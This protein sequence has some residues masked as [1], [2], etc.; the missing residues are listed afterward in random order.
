MKGQAG[1]SIM[2][3]VVG[4]ALLGVAVVVLM[5]GQDFVKQTGQLRD[6]KVIIW[7][8]KRELRAQLVERVK[9]VSTEAAKTAARI[10]KRTPAEKAK[11]KPDACRHWAGHFYAE[12]KEGAE[13]YSVV[14]SPLTER[15][16]LPGFLQNSSFGDAYQ[17]CRSRRSLDARSSQTSTPLCTTLKAAPTTD[18]GM[19]LEKRVAFVEARVAFSDVFGTRHTCEKWYELGAARRIRL[20]YT[21]YSVEL[22]GAG[23]Y[24]TYSGL[25]EGGL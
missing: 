2:E 11:K 13:D 25:Y 14:P 19:F 18:V 15:N 1:F 20:D 8:L 16:D 9:T 10:D 22:T 7:S 12:V 24:K 23:I 5:R 21:I 3:T 4:I 6:E 17:R